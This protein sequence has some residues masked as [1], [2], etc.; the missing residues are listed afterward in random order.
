[1][2]LSYSDYISPFNSYI[3]ST[4]RDLTTVS[5]SIV[6]NEK[7]KMSRILY[8]GPNFSSKSGMALYRLVEVKYGDFFVEKVIFN[9]DTIDSTFIRVPAERFNRVQNTQQ[10]YSNRLGNLGN[11]MISSTTHYRNTSEGVL[12]TFSINDNRD[13]SSFLFLCDFYLYWKLRVMSR[14]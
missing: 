13:R 5:K 14:K 2:N 11:A 3:T 8:C 7:H 1:M 9:R 10:E 4:S 12:K 6:N